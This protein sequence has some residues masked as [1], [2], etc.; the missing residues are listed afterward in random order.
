MT[1]ALKITADRMADSADPSRMMFS[2][3]SPGYATANRAGRIAKYLATSLAI[4]KVVNDPRVINIGKQCKAPH[5]GHGPRNPDRRRDEVLHGESG[6]L[7]QV[8]HHDLGYVVLP[9]GVRDE[10]RRR[11]ERERRLHSSLPVRQRQGGLQSLQPEQDQDADGRERQHRAGV[12]GP[13][14]L[15]VTIH[16]EEPVRAPLDPVVPCRRERPG[17][18]GTQRAVTGG[19]ED[20]K[21][22]DLEQAGHGVGHQNLSGKTKAAMR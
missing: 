18:I 12:H 11:V 4:E 6:H 1:S 14:L 13:V 15:G 2:A 10:R 20:E 8:A 9:V 16:P 3:S 22:P 21:Q 17:Q 19:E 5:Q 7:D